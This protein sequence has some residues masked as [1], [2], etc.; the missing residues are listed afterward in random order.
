ML[1]VLCRSPNTYF[2][3]AALFK[4]VWPS[5]TESSEEIVRTH[6]KVLRR[7]IKLLTSAELINTQRGAGYFIGADDVKFELIALPIVLSGV[8]SRR[9]A[10]WA[11]G[12]RQLAT[13]T[14]WGMQNLA[15]SVD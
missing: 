6:M 7:K 10:R 12:K 2:S 9:P 13:R 4:A 8:A 1:E 11:F 5:E 14:F 3:S 15:I